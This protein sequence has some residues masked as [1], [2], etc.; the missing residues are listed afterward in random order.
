MRVGI[1]L[2]PRVAGPI[3]GELEV[4]CPLVGLDSATLRAFSDG[5][6]LRGKWWGSD[7]EQDRPNLAVEARA[8]RLSALQAAGTPAGWQVCDDPRSVGQLATH[9]DQ[10]NTVTHPFLVSP[11]GISRYAS[12]MVRPAKRESCDVASCVCNCKPRIQICRPCLWFPPAVLVLLAGNYSS[13]GSVCYFRLVQGV[14]ASVACRRAGTARSAQA[15]RARRWHA[16]RVC[17]VSSYFASAG[18]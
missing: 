18:R 17:E 6:L 16:Q 11:S 12:D 1:S 2:P 8:V 7:E 15:S 4:H 3:G 14:G 5:C 13:R 9:R 10:S